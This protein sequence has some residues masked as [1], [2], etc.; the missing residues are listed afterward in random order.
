M[1]AIVGLIIIAVLIYLVI[2]YWVGILLV[3]L[4]GILAYQ[5]YKRGL[6]SKAGKWAASGAAFFVLAFFGWIGSDE[7]T[8]SISASRTAVSQVSTTATDPVS[9]T[10]INATQPAPSTAVVTTSVPTS[11]QPTQQ[12][13][14]AL[15]R[16]QAKVTEVI[17]GDTFKAMVNGKEITIRMLLVDTPETKHPTVGEQPFGKDASNFTKQLISGKTVELEQ[18][19]NN[20]PDKYGRLLYYVYIDGKSVQEQLLEKGL[21]RVAY[22]YAPNVKYVDQYRAI[23]EKAQKAGVGIWS[24]EN[25]AQEDGYHPE[26]NEPTTPKAKAV[27]SKPKEE[28][29]PASAP[30]PESQPVEEVYYANCSAAKAA[31]AAPLYRGDP[32]YRAKLDRDN[33]GVACEK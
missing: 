17:D 14:G 27:V 22:I 19:V 2:T 13:T 21:A 23:Q 25:Y 6:G 4:A 3:A 18:D 5:A 33:D 20:G 30:A 12:T 9:T 8:S 29:Q 11:T 10:S 7:P 15:A 28:S 32:G 31:G 24:V 1:Q 16:I 26:V